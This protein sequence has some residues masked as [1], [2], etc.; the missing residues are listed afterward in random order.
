M[1]EARRVLHF[2]RLDQVI[3]DAD[4]LAAAERA[5][6]LRQLGNWT[7]GQTCGHL[8]AWVDYGYDGI[9]MKIPW[10]V[11]ILTRPMKNSV[12]N[13]PMKPG[14]NIPGVNAGTLAVD[15]LPTEVGV[16]RLRR[17]C[18]RLEAGPPATPHPLY[19]SL[20]AEEWK[21]LKLRHAELHLSFLRAE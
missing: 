19:G 15:L 20:T 21:K 6:K 14:R 2:D 9:P 11:R 5:G 12:L 4:A 3:N 7:L 10:F 1:A 16:D 18:A 8:A 13:K 17:A